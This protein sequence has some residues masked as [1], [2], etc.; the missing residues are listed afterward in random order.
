MFVPNHS[1]RVRLPWNGWLVCSPRN[2]GGGAEISVISRVA[3]EPFLR[4]SIPLFCSHI[5][6]SGDATG[7]SP[8][9]IT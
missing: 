7:N 2:R 8:S 9:A 6:E 3:C 1:R 5:I 4:R